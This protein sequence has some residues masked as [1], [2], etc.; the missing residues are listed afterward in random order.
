MRNGRNS[1]ASKNPRRRRLS[2]T[3]RSSQ[4][5]GA[6]YLVVGGMAMNQHGMLRATAAID[7]LLERSRDNQDKVR[8]ALEIL[9]DKAVREMNETDLEEYTVVR[10]GDEIVVDLML[11][12]CGV[13]YA[14]AAGEVET[15]EVQGAAIPFASAKLLLRTKQTYRERDIPDKIFLERKL[16]EQLS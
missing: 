15:K 16:R 7:L 4:G 11:A 3:V 1:T 5:E 9:P 6:R 14:D 2:K 10:V 12:A 13:T 8:K